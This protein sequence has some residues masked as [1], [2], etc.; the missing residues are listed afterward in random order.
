MR[1]CHEDTTCAVTA[2]LAMCLDTLASTVASWI[3][4]YDCLYEIAL[5]EMQSYDKVDV[6]ALKHLHKHRVKLAANAQR[7]DGE[8]QQVLAE[9]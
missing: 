7:E 6:A 9:A 3:H 5:R 1:C 4:V 8:P 2:V